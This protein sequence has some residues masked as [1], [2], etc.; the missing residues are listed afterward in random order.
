MPEPGAR[1]STDAVRY[2]CSFTQE[3]LVDTSRARPG[4]PALN[5]SARYRIRG[6]LRNSVLETAWKTLVARHEMLRARFVASEGGFATVV[7]RFTPSRVS[8][9]D[10]SALDPDIVDAE[11][12]RIAAYEARSPLDISQAPLFR[13]TRVI[14][15]PT[16]CVLLVTAHRLVCDEWSFDI[17]ARELGS[18]CAAAVAG[19]PAELPPL[20]TNFG[21]Y[22]RWQREALTDDALDEELRLVASDFAGP[23][24]LQIETDFPRPSRRGSHVRTRARDLDPLATRRFIEAAREI[25]STPFMATLAG[26]AL[27]LRAN[28]DCDTLVVTTHVANRNDVDLACVVGPFVNTLP[29][30]LD[31]TRASTVATLLERVGDAVANALE[32]QH[33][34]FERI[35]P[36]AG[37][38][39][40]APSGINFAYRNAS[41]AEMDCGSFAIVSEPSALGGSHDEVSFTIVER[42]DG[43]QLTCTYDPELF[44][45]AT[46]DAIFDRFEKIVAAGIDLRDPV[47][48]FHGDLFADGF[49]AREIAAA[50]T[51]RRIVPVAPH[52]I[53]ARPILPTIDAMAHDYVASLDTIVATGPYRLVGFC[54]GAL[55]AYEVARLLKARGET[56]EDVI[57]I[58]AEAP[59]EPIL[60]FCD[61]IIRAIASNERLVPRVREVACY[62]IAHLN[63]AMSAGASAVVRYVA[64]LLRSGAMRAAAPNRNSSGETFVRARGE[65]VSEVSFVHIGAA[66]SHRPHPYDGHVTLVWSDEQPS[67][68]G[69]TTQGWNRL[70]ASVTT[71]R[72]NGGHVAPLHELVGDLSSILGRLLR[73]SEPH[74]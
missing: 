35:A 21:D 22:A 60:P 29:L 57:L 16:D 56:V 18:L 24:A 73:Q 37:F 68:T 2:P 51:D 38:D 31:L 14:C 42:F 28:V 6:E 63:R 58:N 69:E 20:S 19:T 12:D 52:G 27:A 13:V 47:L 23:F 40:G 43:W 44:E 41:S 45:D 48:F 34:P 64:R 66:L 5:V 8:I 10:C 74:A 30:R 33:V 50:I 3:R 54:A 72:M 1:A 25:G 61:R 9:V 11:I 39:G 53:G 17:L 59:T 67:L 4:D 70:A 15:S 26:M 46:I 65:S 7:D 32:L 49:Y 62:N 55:V 71:V 36:I